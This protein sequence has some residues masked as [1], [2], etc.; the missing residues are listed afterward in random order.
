[1]QTSNLR[2]N[3]QTMGD[4]TRLVQSGISQLEGHFEKILRNETPRSV[5]PLHYITKDM[6]FPVLSQATITP[7]G[8]V[9]AYVVGRSGHGHGE[10]ASQ[11]SAVSKIYVDVRGPY[12]SSSLVNLAAASVN[13]ARKKNPDA[14]Y[15]VGTNG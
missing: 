3:Q 13:T 4:L 1:M 6:P 11:E 7:L 2:A 15:R 8:L 14:M 9:R 5:E 12:L 10:A